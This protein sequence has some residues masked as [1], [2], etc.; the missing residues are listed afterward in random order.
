MWL[1]LITQGT[2][3]THWLTFAKIRLSCAWVYII[4]LPVLTGKQGNTGNYFLYKPVQYTHILII[5]HMTWYFSTYN[6]I[7]YLF[8]ALPNPSV[9]QIN[10]TTLPIALDLAHSAEHGLS[11]T[12]DVKQEHHSICWSFCIDL[13]WSNKLSS[14][15]N[16]MRWFLYKCDIGCTIVVWWAYIERIK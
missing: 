16:P 2:L 15:N 10:F 6:M 4:S 8:W 14:R 9:Q 1:N 13:Y 12:V 5:I 3:S 11:C 7:H